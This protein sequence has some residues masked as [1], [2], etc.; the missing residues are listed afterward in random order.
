VP[1]DGTAIHLTRHDDLWTVHLA[2]G[3]NLAARAVVLA[4]G[5]LLIPSDPFDTSLIAPF[6]FRNP[7]AAESVQGLSP[8]TPVLLIGTGLT[9][10]DVAL[11]LRETGHRGPI[12]A[13]SRHGRLYKFHQPYTPRPLESLP[14]EFCSPQAALRWIRLETQK[15]EAAG[16]E[17]RAI[18]D[19][20]RPHTAAIW[21]GW[22]LAQRASFLRH[23]RNLWDLHRHRMAPEIAAQLKELQA[24]GTLSIHAGRVLSAEA[25]GQL[26][27]ITLRSTQTGTPLT[28]R[29]AR[30]INCTGPARDYSRV[31][32]PL[33]VSLRE[34]GWLTPDPLRLG[35]ETD[36]DGRL[37]GTDGCPVSGL[38]TLG[39]LRIP[40]LWESIAIP[41]IRI[42]AAEL[43][44]L[45]VSESVNALF[46]QAEFL[47]GRA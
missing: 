13:V 9:M 29:V 30:V 33:V 7:W 20:L 40:G 4:I 16:S 19:S 47:P 46:S 3:A 2:D 38:F 28:L 17:W 31:E 8:D 44:K 27:K 21:R 35:I 41:E 42:Q 18:I 15:A 6:Y 37:I 39:P 14:A 26:A 25:E 45:L 24:Q 1:V 5:N 11:S 32:F 36:P 12:H 10:V 22:N 23:A 34:N 43:A